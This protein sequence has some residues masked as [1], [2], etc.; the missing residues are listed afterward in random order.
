MNTQG[1]L[2]EVRGRL[3]KL[4]DASLID[5]NSLYREIVLGLKAFGNDVMEESEAVVEVK[6]GK[7]ELPQ[8]FHQLKLA[9]LCEPLGYQKSSNIEFHDLQSS[10]FYRERVIN[11]DKWNECDPCCKEKEENIIKENLYFNDSSVSFYYHRPR[12]LRLG[13][14]FN[15]GKCTSDCRN[16]G[17]RDNFGTIDISGRTLHTNFK[18]GYIYIRYFGL[19]EEEGMVQIPETPNGFLEK[20]LENRLLVDVAITAIANNEAPQLA[21]LLPYWTQERELYYKKAS[22]ELKMQNLQPDRLRRRV[23]R[24][25]T[26]ERLQYEIR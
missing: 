17:V 22:N 16:R 10:Y 26:L 21:N 13:K 14:T 20:Y 9:Y 11:T 1:L 15:R 7:A 5:D 3:S 8:G 12:L 24:L 4:S 6:D 25:N 23:R 2:Y 18:E 19:A